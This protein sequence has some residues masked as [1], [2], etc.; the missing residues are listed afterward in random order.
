MKMKRFIYQA[1]GK[2]K[3]V[4]AVGVF[5][6]I[7]KTGYHLYLYQTFV[8]PSFGRNLISVSVLDKS[9]YHCSFG[10]RKFGLYKDSVLIGT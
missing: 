5:K 1:D 6:V 7:L 8:V 4:E 9:G 2:A 3:E 10:D